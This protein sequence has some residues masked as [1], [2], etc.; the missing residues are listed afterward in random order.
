MKV[1]TKVINEYCES[2]CYQC[3][4]YY[5][6]SLGSRFRQSINKDSGTNCYCG[7]Y[8]IHKIKK[9]KRVSIQE[10]LPYLL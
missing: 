2:K 7:C 9:K 4:G 1:Y 8:G 3:I 6:I 5:R 10:V